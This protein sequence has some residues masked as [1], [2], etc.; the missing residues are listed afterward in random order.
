MSSRRSQCRACIRG[1]S[2]RSCVAFAGFVAFPGVPFAFESRPVAFVAS[3]QV[4][5]VCVSCVRVGCVS[6]VCVSVGCVRVSA[7]CVRA[8]VI[9]ISRPT[10]RAAAATDRPAV[11][12]LEK[13]IGSALTKVA[14]PRF[15]RQSGGPAT[16]SVDRVFPCCR[17]RER[18]WNRDG[19][20]TGV[21]DDCRK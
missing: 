13:R 16:T 18:R 9:S 5:C 10:R 14:V 17:P 4:A 7:S 12:R 11:A 6:V 3:C 21:Q 8:S 2:R 19:K 1:R 15:K 20:H